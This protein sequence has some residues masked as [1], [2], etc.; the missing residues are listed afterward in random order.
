MSSRAFG[1]VLIIFGILMA[2]IVANWNFVEAAFPIIF[3]TL[4]FTQIVV[5]YAPSKNERKEQNDQ[6]DGLQ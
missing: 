3:V 2:L 6:T 1:Y 5:S 4:G